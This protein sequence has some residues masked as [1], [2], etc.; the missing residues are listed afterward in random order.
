M[1]SIKEVATAYDVSDRTVRNWLEAARKQ[2]GSLGIMRAGK[3]MFTASEVTTLASYGRQ[4]EQEVIE[5][6]FV[7]EEG[8]HREVKSLSV[9]SFSSLEQFR[10]TRTRQALAN[11]REF[12]GQV[13]GLLSELE[14]CMDLAEA[15]QEQELLL[16]KQTKRQAQQRIER[17]RRRA[18]EYRLKTDILAT[19]Q[20]ADLDD[21]DDL[22]DEV[23]SMGKPQEPSLDAS[24]G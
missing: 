4:V 21:L 9:P 10:T 17:F 2:H 1:Q 22:A 8:N 23:S 24:N 5:P 7:V 15:E 14:Q 11:P 6:E 13:D 3:L 19:I 18:D 20:N 16:T 12:V